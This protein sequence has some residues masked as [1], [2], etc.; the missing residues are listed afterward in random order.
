[1]NKAKEKQTEPEIPHFFLLALKKNK[2][3]LKTFESFSNSHKREYIQWITNAKKEETRI[4]RMEK[5]IEML[6]KGK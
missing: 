1:M 3:A 2:E 6:S 4:S 5:A